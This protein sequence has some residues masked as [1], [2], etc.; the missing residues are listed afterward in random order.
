MERDDGEFVT[1]QRGF[2]SDGSGVNMTNNMAGTSMSLTNI[3][4]GREGDG[5]RVPGVGRGSLGLKPGS[6]ISLAERQ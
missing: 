4:V 5:S 3:E 6:D 2:K 1:A